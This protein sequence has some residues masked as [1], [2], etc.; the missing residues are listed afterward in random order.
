M[1]SCCFIKCDADWYGMS[2]LAGGTNNYRV[3]MDKFHLV[4]TAF[5]QLGQ[6]Y[7]LQSFAYPYLII[8]KSEV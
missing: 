8:C 4:S 1:Q 6:G 7:F 3:L 2:G 5:L